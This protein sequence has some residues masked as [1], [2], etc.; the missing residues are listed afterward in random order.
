VAINPSQRDYGHESSKTPLVPGALRLYR[1]FRVENAVLHPMNS[2]FRS[3]NPYQEPQELYKARCLREDRA[4]S[5]GWATQVS[6][7]SGLVTPE[8]GEAPAKTCQCGFYAHY[9]QMTDFYPTFDWAVKDVREPLRN[10]M[11]VKSVIEVSGRV[12]M[13]TKGIRG[14]K[15]KLI[16]IAPD[17]TKYRSK[18]WTAAVE[19]AR[20]YVEYRALRDNPE[21]FPVNIDEQSAVYAV[22]AELARKY[23]VG[24]FGNTAVMHDRFPPQDVSELLKEE[25]P[26]MPPPRKAWVVD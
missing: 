7:A 13:G 25:D 23:G 12:V 18:E 15:L 10:N 17:W 26:N 24:F 11:I 9:D 6:R 3:E 14:E 2:M 20:T 1:H 4:S 5:V 16:A 8:H 22:M 19:S 21:K